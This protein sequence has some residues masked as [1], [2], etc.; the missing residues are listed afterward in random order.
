MSSRRG[1]VQVVTR[2]GGWM[3]PD[4]EERCSSH[5]R[6]TLR[7]T[8]ALRAAALAACSALFLASAAIAQAAPAKPAACSSSVRK[9]M[10]PEWARGG[11]SG[12][13]PV[14][15]QALGRSGNIVAILWADRDPLAS[16]PRADRNNKILWVARLPF[17][18]SKLWIRAQRM[19][20]TRNVGRPVSRVLQGGPG[21][22]IVDLPA[23][24]CWR[25]ALHWSGRSDSVDLRYAAKGS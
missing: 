12:P 4:G 7:T 18:Y 23:P 3:E 17:G 24:G 8:R 25:L 22:S 6:L 15:P 9:A 20:G 13:E 10:L 5:M 1:E 16:P 21:P 14:M 2:S 11:F 19:E